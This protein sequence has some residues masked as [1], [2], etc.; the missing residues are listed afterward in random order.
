M[1]S[2]QQLLRG[3]HNKIR[4]VLSNYAQNQC[5]NLR[6]GVN[7]DHLGWRIQNIVHTVTTLITLNY[8]LLKQ[9]G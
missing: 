7:S 4:W 2:M 5:C 6:G 8:H 1:S 9:V 3:R